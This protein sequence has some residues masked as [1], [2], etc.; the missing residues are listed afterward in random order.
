M[1][2]RD[3]CR[4]LRWLVW[5]TG[6]FAFVTAVL[7]MVL[8]HYGRS[9]VQEEDG[10]RQLYTVLGYM[11]NVVRALLRGERPPMLSFS[12]GQGMDVMTTCTYYGY[13]DPL[14]LLS[15]FFRGGSV[16]YGYAL[17]ALLRLYLAGVCFGIGFSGSIPHNFIK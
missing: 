6:L 16:E 7:L 11:G 9:L 14:C 15:A 17:I 5:Y 10:S 1:S 4:G 2:R 13:T 8:L 3:G 12:L